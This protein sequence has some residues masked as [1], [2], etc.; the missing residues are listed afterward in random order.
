MRKILVVDDD[1]YVSK[2]V[3]R[4]LPAGQYEIQAVGSG[5]EAKKAFDDFAPDLLL[6]DI[7]MPGMSGIELCKFVREHLQ[8]REIMIIMLTAKDSQHDRLQAFQYGAD[9]YITKPFHIDSLAR[10]INFIFEKR[11]VGS[12]EHRESPPISPFI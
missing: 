4:L 9:D 3:S 11:E 6:L 10:K 12:R 5:E 7:M 1:P 8:Y 2:I